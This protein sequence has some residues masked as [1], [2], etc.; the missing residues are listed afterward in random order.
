[1]NINVVV[2]IK[3]CEYFS[4]WFN[5]Q[6][7]VKRINGSKSREEEVKNL[8]DSEVS[9]KSD[10]VECQQLQEEQLKEL[11]LLQTGNCLI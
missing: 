4:F 10:E 7:C 3:C 2:R 8:L 6:A 11:E 1:M 5:Y 9:D